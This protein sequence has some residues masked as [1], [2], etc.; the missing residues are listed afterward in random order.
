MKLHIFIGCIFMLFAT[1]SFAAGSTLAGYHMKVDTSDIKSLQRG[2]RIFVNYCMGCHSAAYMRYNRLGKDLGITEE[3]L[4]SNFMFGTDKPGDT[5][6]IAMRKSDALGFFGI[7]PPDLSVIAR[8]RGVDWLYGY[9][10]TFYSDP[11]KPFGV[12]NLQFKDVA[13]PHVLWELQGTHK[14]VYK[15]VTHK[16]GT[17]VEVI[18]GLEQVSPGKLTPEE[19]KATIHDLINFLVYLSEPAKLQRQKIGIWVII[20]LLSF[21]V[22]AYLL[23]NEYWKDI[24]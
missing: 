16:D 10:M 9:F 20:Y 17:E 23:K 14:P 19:Y 2:A 22:L 24:N 8:S 15:T 21:L 12:N 13:M 11:A 3:V 6:N 18:D 1:A 7:A 5:M 4:K